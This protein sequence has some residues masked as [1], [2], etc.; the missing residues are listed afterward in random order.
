MIARRAIAA[1]ILV[2]ALVP[3]CDQP[4]MADQRK[5]E[6][7][8]AGEFAN[9]TSAL[10]PPE[11]TVAREAELDPVS[12]QPPVSPALLE[13]GRTVYDAVCAPCHSR[14]G[15][16]EG[17]IVERGYP[18]PPSFHTDRLRGTAD[19]HFYDVISKGYGIM[20]AY[21]DRVAP[22]DRWAITA[23]I[24]ALQLSQH[25]DVADLPAAL[26][27]QLPPEGEP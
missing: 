4:Q 23:Y 21:A 25:A 18:A 7:Y 12:E 27:N 15:D 10:Q 5:Y 1:S 14:L 13:R 6:P 19:R 8:E 16:G 22:E 3:A 26:R 2:A 9:G 17:I 24:R 11:G 20:Y